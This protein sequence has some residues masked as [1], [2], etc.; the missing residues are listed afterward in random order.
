[1]RDL[2]AR[3]TQ[4]Q[5]AQRFSFTATAARQASQP[6][7]CILLTHRGQCSFGFGR[8]SHLLWLLS[9]KRGRQFCPSPSPLCCQVQTQRGP[10]LPLLP[11]PERRDGPAPGGLAT[12]N[13]SEQDGSL[14]DLSMHLEGGGYKEPFVPILLPSLHPPLSTR[15]QRLCLNDGC[16]PAAGRMAGKNDT[17]LHRQRKGW[18]ARTHAHSGLPVTPAHTEHPQKAAGS[19]TDTEFSCMVDPRGVL[20]T[21]RI[22]LHIATRAPESQRSSTDLCERQ[23][24]QQRKA[25]YR[26]PCKAIWPDSQWCHPR[27]CTLRPP[28]NLHPPFT[29]ASG[30]RKKQITVLLSR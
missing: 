6:D 1:M 12:S 2:S 3:R 29:I 13:A 19:S 10:L 28:E 18:L 24:F 11:Q 27:I 5:P 25:G 23:V 4:T 14:Q 16:M 15:R 9:G 7:P 17:S 21:S 26:V 30:G 22:S 8:V 20:E